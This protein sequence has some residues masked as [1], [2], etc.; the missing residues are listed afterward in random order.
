MC[1]RRLVHN[2][3]QRDQHYNAVYG[4]IHCE[5]ADGKHV[6]E[7]NTIFEMNYLIPIF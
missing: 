7:L 1:S 3:E 6:V 4:S 5:K 2:L